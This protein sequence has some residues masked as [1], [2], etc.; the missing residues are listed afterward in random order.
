MSNPNDPRII[1]LPEVMQKTGASKA[2]IY[3]WIKKNNFP[4]PLKIGLR[5]VGWLDQE[6][7]GWI[8][9]RPRADL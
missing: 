3:R 9:S 4:K 7:N 1:R 8:E 5:S 2:N 6:I